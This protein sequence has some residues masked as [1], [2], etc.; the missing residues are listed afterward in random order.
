MQVARSF[1]H[2]AED[3]A[4]KVKRPD[5]FRHRRV[6][7]IVPSV[8][9]D[10]RPVPRPHPDIA[11]EGRLLGDPFEGIP[12]EDW[13]FPDALRLYRRAEAPR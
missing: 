9:D 3:A 10:D 2:L 6:E 11:G 12:S 5:S 8:D 1:K 13:D 7:V 4:L